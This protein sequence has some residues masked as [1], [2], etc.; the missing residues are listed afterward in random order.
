MEVD[1]RIK[2]AFLY[3]SNSR[4]SIPN[5]GSIWNKYLPKRL[6]S[7]FKTALTCFSLLLIQWYPRIA[8][9]KIKQINDHALPDRKVVTPFLSS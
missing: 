9:Q 1:T 4:A 7:E 2:I 6:K 5:A 8:I 3:L